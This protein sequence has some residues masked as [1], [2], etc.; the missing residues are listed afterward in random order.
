MLSDSE[1]LVPVTL[2]AMDVLVEW[3]GRSLGSSEAKVSAERGSDTGPSGTDVVDVRRLVARA[4]DGPRLIPESVGVGSLGPAT[5]A[6][7]ALGSVLSFGGA[8]DDVFLGLLSNIVDPGAG[9]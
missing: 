8:G 3:K 9:T 6:S 2:D 5:L 4:L 1:Y 7:D